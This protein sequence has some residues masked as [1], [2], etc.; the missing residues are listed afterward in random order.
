V[1]VVC[2]LRGAAAVP[3]VR[4]AG[5]RPRRGAPH[6]MHQDTPPS[7]ALC[8]TAVTAE[9]GGMMRRSVLSFRVPMPIA[10]PRRSGRMLGQVP[11][12]DALRR[13]VSESPC[14][15]ASELA[16]GSSMFPTPRS[17]LSEFVAVPLAAERRLARRRNGAPR[18]RSPGRPARGLSDPAARLP[19]A[20]A[21]SGHAPQPE[22]PGSQPRGRRRLL[23]HRRGLR[24]G[25]GG[26]TGT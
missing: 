3:S 17:P 1:R 8:L 19:A 11:E 15:C 16:E 6:V 21:A 13:A 20:E 12:Q 9:S 18:G 26:R 14:S 5:R 10:R 7:S 24:L 25:S 2:T 23:T 22:V 4:N